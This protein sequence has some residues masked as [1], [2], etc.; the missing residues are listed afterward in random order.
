MTNY[1]TRVLSLLIASV[2]IA[3]SGA[4]SGPDAAILDAGV[5]D[6]GEMQ[7]PDAGRVDA[8]SLPDAGLRPDAG[9][10]VPPLDLVRYHTGNESDFAGPPAGPGLVM[11]GGGREVDAA[12]SWWRSRVAGGDVVILRTSGSDGYNDY[13]YTDIGGVDSVETLLVTSRALAASDY[14]TWRVRTAEGIFMAGGDQSTYLEAWKGTPLQDALQQAWLR[15]A[16]LGG[17]SAGLAVLGEHIFAA[18]EGSVGSSDAL[19]NPYH[20]RVA[21]DS[22]F[23][24][25]PPLAG[26]ITDSHFGARDRMGRLVTFLARLHADGSAG[27]R[28]GLGFDERTALVVDEHGVGTVM[29]SG[30]VYA[31]FA[32]QPAEECTA[33]MPLSYLNVSYAT[34]T[35]GQTIQLPSGTTDEPRRVLSA[36][37]GALLPADPY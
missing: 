22:D 7:P 13:L 34:L 4:S 16:V 8:A 12:F 33:G 14:V 30:A 26:V 6:V 18:Y 28:V 24:A 31:V 25:L 23:L 37:A 19:S 11:M 5:P 27:A 20:P 15:G 36:Q 10:P 1:V 32:S 2:G 29:G 17:T 3:C 35:A 21:L 9:L